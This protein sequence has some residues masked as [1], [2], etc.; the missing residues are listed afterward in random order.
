MLPEQK[1][2]AL[3]WDIKE[4]AQDI[5]DFIEGMSSKDFEAN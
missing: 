1:D 3:L 5:L 2:R 4:A